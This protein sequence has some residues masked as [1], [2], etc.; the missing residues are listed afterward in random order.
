MT[1]KKYDYIIIYCFLFAS[2]TVYC[3]TC[4]PVCGE[5]AKNG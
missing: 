4:S 5:G 2:I 3:G 1:A